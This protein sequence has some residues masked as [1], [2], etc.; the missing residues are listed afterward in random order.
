M[1]WRPNRQWQRSGIGTVVAVLFAL[2]LVVTRA[3][4]WVCYASTVPLVMVL[5]PYTLIPTAAETGE[6]SS[7]A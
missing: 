7:D 5:V 1:T 2:V 3:P 6:R 4:M